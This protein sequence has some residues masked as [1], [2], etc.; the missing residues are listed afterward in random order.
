MHTYES[1]HKPFGISYEKYTIAPGMKPAEKKSCVMS[2][3]CFLGGV[4]SETI[5]IRHPRCTLHSQHPAS[6]YITG[7]KC[8]SEICLHK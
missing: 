7:Q 4:V 3:I 1:M 2:F 5:D 6:I 8:H